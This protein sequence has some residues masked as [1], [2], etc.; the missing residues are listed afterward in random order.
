MKKSESISEISAALSELQAEVKD[1]F[2]AATGYGYSYA[3]LDAILKDNRPLLSKRGLSF[4]QSE[5]FVENGTMQ[6][7]EGLLMHKSGEWIETTSEA[8]YQQMKG[9]NSAQSA[10]SGYTYLRRYNLAALIGISSDEDADAK[11]EP[12]KKTETLNGYL[13]THG[14]AAK[15]FA[16]HFLITNKSMAEALLSDKNK[17]DAM[18]ADYKAHK[19]GENS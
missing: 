10:G 12:A 3:T 13:K 5:T 17:L 4:S 2:K 18:I 9:M 11:G 14:I 15:D 6:R 8:P 7:V 1:T 16:Q 19:N